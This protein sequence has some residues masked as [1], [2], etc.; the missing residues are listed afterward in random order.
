MCALGLELGDS[1]HCKALIAHQD[2]SYACGLVVDPYRYLA[3]ENLTVWRRIDKTQAGVG[4]ASLKG[5]C[6]DM[7]A[8]G[9]GCDSGG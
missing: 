8:T 9:K 2:G 6:R 5:M 1:T 7:L 4:E 3:E